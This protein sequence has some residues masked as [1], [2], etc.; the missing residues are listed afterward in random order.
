MQPQQYSFWTWFAGYK[1]IDIYQ[2]EVPVTYTELKTLD[3]QKKEITLPD[4]TNI[5]LNSGTTL[6]Y[7]NTFG[8]QNREVFL[9]G[10]AYFNVTRDTTKT[11]I[12]RT[13]NITIKSFGYKL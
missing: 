8:Q 7:A 2:K 10:E 12:V 4:G 6:K 5:W 13:D 3:G 9:I 1:Y 11:F